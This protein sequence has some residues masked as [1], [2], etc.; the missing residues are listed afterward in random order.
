METMAR[1]AV[2]AQAPEDREY[3][4]GLEKG[5]LIIEAFGAIRG[6]ATLTRLAEYTGHSKASVR[7]SL[8]T[9]CKLGFAT[10]TGRDFQLAPRALRLGHAYVVSDR[11][12]RVAQPVLEMVSERT[13][14]SCSIAVLDSQDVVFVARSTQRRSLSTGL[15]AGARLPAYCSATGRVLLSDQPRHAVEFL[16]NRMSRPALTPHTRTGLDEILAQ[17]DQARAL[18]YATCDEELELG[19]RSLAVPVRNPAGQ[20]VAA[21]SL[22]VVGPRMSCEEMAHQ[23][24]P[25]LENARR[26]V[27]ELL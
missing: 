10:Q 24:V 20:V 12:T 23:F 11:L 3:V 4:M 26:Q 22:S 13:R 18:G 2:Q 17:V 9:L 21:M 19:L 6:P 14:E 25:E 5:L 15:G 7:R 16:L 8:L 1:A 27:G